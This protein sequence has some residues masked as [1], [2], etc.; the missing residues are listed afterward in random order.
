M[1][2]IDLKSP[3]EVLRS[4]KGGIKRPSEIEAEI[5]PKTRYGTQK[6]KEAELI[7]FA[8]RYGGVLVIEGRD[9]LTEKKE[10]FAIS[11]ENYGSEVVTYDDVWPN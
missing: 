8:V 11:P 1:V 2:G 10:V 4:I 7:E 6:F 5:R 9:V 3:S